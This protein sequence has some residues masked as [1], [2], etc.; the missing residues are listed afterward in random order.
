MEEVFSEHKLPTEFASKVLEGVPALGW[1]KGIE[2]TFIGAL[3]AALAATERPYSYTDMMGWSGLAFRVRWFVPRED[4][5]WC[6]S[7]A[8]GEMPEAIDAVAR[9]TGWPLRPD[10]LDAADS[11]SVRRISGQM[12]AA[13][14]GG[15][16]VL[17]YNK[18][19]DMGVAYGYEQGGE[20]LLLRD[21]FRRDEPLRLR[22]AEL[23]FLSIFLGEA[24]EPLSPR[25]ALTQAL[26]LAVS[27]WRREQHSEGPGGY[28]LGRAALREWAQ[29]LANA[30]QFD[31]QAQRQLLGVSWWCFTTLDDARR[32]AVRF[33]E[34]QAPLVDGQARAALERARGFYAEE[35]HLFGGAVGRRDAFLGPWS[36]KAFQD[37]TDEVRARECALL[38]EASRLEEQAVTEVA[39]AL[40]AMGQ[41]R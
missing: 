18:G 8:V 5:R 33:L 28:W 19:L 11:A 23:G 32:A 34:R 40:A 41:T 10:F 36:G 12:V 22:P 9:A 38:A 17:A 4:T 24:Q 37:W 6:P 1:G 31:E 21:Y 15:R 29:D 16:P 7:C 2:C 27:N 39:A 20:S 26:E 14:D 35:S 3:E 30:A 25:A 13:I